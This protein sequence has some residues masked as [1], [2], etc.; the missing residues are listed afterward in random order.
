MTAVPHWICGAPLVGAGPRSPVF[1]PSLG[2]RAG[3]VALATVDEVDVAVRAA[4]G[5]YDSW[6]RTSAARR[7]RVMFAFKQLLDTH[8]A[9][10]ARII[11]QEHGKTLKDA[12]GEVMRSIEVVEF[13]C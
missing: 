5:A 6:S 8:R 4:A 3:E 9:E 12:D 7:A 13:A 11:S 1:N 2:S 10:L